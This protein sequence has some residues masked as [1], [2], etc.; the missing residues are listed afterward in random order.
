MS[1]FVRVLFRFRQ[2]GEDIRRASAVFSSK[3]SQFRFSLSQVFEAVFRLVQIFKFR[4]QILE[5]VVEIVVEGL[6][7]LG[8]CEKAI[9]ANLRKRFFDR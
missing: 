9:V 6:K 2:I 4:L 7:A 8:Q 1:D 3:R 5:T